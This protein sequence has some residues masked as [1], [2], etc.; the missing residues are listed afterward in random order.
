MRTWLARLPREIPESARQHLFAMFEHS[1][2][3]GLEFRR[4]NKKYLILPL[5]D[6]S[7]VTCL[8]NILSAFFDFM[9]KHGGFGLAGACFDSTRKCVRPRF[10]RMRDVRSCC[11]RMR[12]D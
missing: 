4:Q 5:P 10:V 12:V 2:D 1:I 9:A 6:L 8:C 7:L 3:K 11:V